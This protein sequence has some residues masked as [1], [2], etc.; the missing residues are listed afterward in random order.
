MAKLSDKLEQLKNEHAQEAFEKHQAVSD[1]NR[2][3]ETLFLLGRIRQTGHIARA[4][5]TGLSA[6]EIRALV[7][8]QE[9][10]RYLDLGY[11][12]F[13][14]FLENSEYSPMSKTRFYERLRVLESEG[15]EIYDLLTEM[16]ISISTRKLLTKG[17]RRLELD[18]DDLIVGT[19]RVS[20]VDNPPI[21]R[22]LIKDLAAEIRD[23]ETEKARVTEKLERAESQN[24]RGREEY[25]ALQRRYDLAVETSE[26]D[27]CWTHVQSSLHRLGE[28]AAD[29][30]AD[31][32]SSRGIAIMKQIAHLTFAVQDGFGIKGGIDLESIAVRERAAAAGSS[33]ED[34]MLA[35]FDEED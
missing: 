18:G 20:V 29:L 19:E 22:Q 14:E 23:A 5:A 30:P 34:R 32:Q 17:D 21:I 2:R 31:E 11:A 7:Q 33:L 9:D 10:R 1:E 8:F 3:S 16:G 35:E 15:D 27:R 12:N 24:A 25:Q 28:L 26:F 13:V 6:Q 4:V